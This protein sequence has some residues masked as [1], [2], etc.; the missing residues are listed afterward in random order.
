[1][2]HLD[3]VGVLGPGRGADGDHFRAFRD[4][5]A[6]RRRVGEAPEAMAAV[7]RSD[8]GRALLS[9]LVGLAWVAHRLGQPDLSVVTGSDPQVP[10]LRLPVPQMT[11]RHYEAA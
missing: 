8:G 2:V 6:H 9:P 7:L 5:P 1:M 4:Q 11:A 3:L 10:S